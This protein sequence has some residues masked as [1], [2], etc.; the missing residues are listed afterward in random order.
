MLDELLYGADSDV[1]EQVMEPLACKVVI[2]IAAEGD[3]DLEEPE[4]V[5]LK[6]VGLGLARR[7]GK[8][9]G[10]E[11]VICAVGKHL[12]DYRAEDGIELLHK[13]L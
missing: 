2:L 10:E 13:S 4:D 8:A 7:G 9:P 1:V 3:D 12:I 6:Q 5:I 11:S